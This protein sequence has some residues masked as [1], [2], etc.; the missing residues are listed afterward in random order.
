MSYSNGNATNNDVLD[1]KY[2]IAT[3]QYDINVSDPVHKQ[4]DTVSNINLQLWFDN[5]P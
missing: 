3:N 1:M 4:R 5:L 2:V